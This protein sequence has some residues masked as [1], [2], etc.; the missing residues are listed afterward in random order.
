LF[1]PERLCEHT[2]VR[3]GNLTIEAEQQAALPGY[4]EPAVVRHFDAPEALDVRFYEVRA[5]SALNRVPD[6]SR[7]PFRWTINPYRGCTHACSYCLLGETRV[8]MADGSARPIADLRQGDAIVGTERI[9]GERRYV[10]TEVLAHW[11][12]LRPAHCVT[13]DGGETL[14]ASADHRFL[15]ARGWRHVTEP[16]GPWSSRP[17][18][19][20]G[21]KLLG[22]GRLVPA[23][24][25]GQE[26]DPE[27]GVPV[28]SIQDLGAEMRLFDIT[29]GTGDFIANGVI[30]HNCFARPTHA[31]L[32]FGADRDFERE[33]VV[34]VNAPEVLRAEL[35]RPSWKGEHVAMGTNTDPYQ[36]VEGRY[37]LM[38]GIW[39][40]LRD[41]ANPCSVLTKSPLV[42]RDLD[43]LREIAEVT[44][45]SVSFSI[46]T[47]DERTWRSTEP[48]TPH[49]RARLDA[50]AE[51]SD[52]GIPV[53]VLVA[54]LMPGIN[55]D[56]AQ[57]EEI[58][59]L[60]TEAGASM[61]GGLALHLRGEVRSVFM[62]WLRAARP[63]LVERYERLYAGGAYAPPAERHRLARL[64]RRCAPD[65]QFPNGAARPRH[66]PPGSSALTRP[67]GT[68]QQ[69]LF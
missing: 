49:P 16:H 69:T 19:A 15:T 48:H 37:R 20:I 27:E 24:L 21:T 62:D 64:V 1:L 68:R 5:R 25:E 22:P 14:I 67:P 18:L 51:L 9:G 42:V 35:A 53:G 29:T 58:V 23:D 39:A 17:H 30:S 45:V 38:R 57:V 55:D 7:V 2:F 60:A 50:V 12:T 8:L 59:R 6:R 44:S 34:K 13:L 41:A 47:L 63:D 40:A 33:I 52:A 31:Y 66:L 46:P 43:L 11:S 26:V 32:G 10:R 61:I 3:W 36:W 56:A 54:P 65:T 4:R 28:T